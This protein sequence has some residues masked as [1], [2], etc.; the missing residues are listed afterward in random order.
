M[1]IIQEKQRKMSSSSSYIQIRVLAA[2]TGTTYPINLPENE[3]TVENI[4]RHLAAVVPKEDQ[5][6]LL[7]PP[8]KVPKDQTLR[9]TETLSSL[10]LGDMEDTPPS[11]FREDSQSDE[12]SASSRRRWSIL[13]TKDNTGAKRLFLFSKKALSDSAP[14]P[15]PC[16]LHPVDINIPSEPDPSPILF[17]DSPQPSSPLHQALSVYERRFMLHLCQ[18][19]A[20]ADGADL[21]L[22]A[23]RSCIFEQAVMVRALR[24][25]VSNLSDHWNN[26]SRTRAD[27]TSL[28]ME[29]MDEHGKMLNGLDGIL[30]NLGQINLHKELKAIARI[31]GREMETLLDTVPVERERRWANQCQVAYNRL[32]EHFEEVKGEFENLTSTSKRSEE[33]ESDLDT[34]ARVKALEDEVYQVVVKVRNDQ[35]L[36][37]TKLTED[38]KTVVGV[39]LN[40]INDNDR[41][42]AAFTTLE[43]MSKASSDILPLMEADDLKLKEV[44]LKVAEAKTNAMKH[45]QNRLRQI[46]QAQL[47]I[48]RV[49]KIVSGLKAA[50]VQQCEDMT[51]VAH[52]VELPSAYRDFLAEIRRRRAYGEAVTSISNNMIEQITALRDDEVKSREKFLR[53]SGRHLMPSFF[54]MFVPTLATPPPLFT[55][56]LP[57]NIELNELPNISEAES[58]PGDST[59]VHGN[60][61]TSNTDQ[62]A[63]SLTESLPASDAEKDPVLDSISRMSITKGDG[64]SVGKTHNLIISTEEQSDTD[65]IMK[66]A[67]DVVKAECDMKLKTLA[68]ENAALR[69]SLERLGG[70]PSKSFVEDSQEE[71]PRDQ[72]KPTITEETASRIQLDLESTKKELEM[73][74]SE[75]DK[76]NT[77]LAQMKI[78]SNRESDKISHS[79]FK[80][81]DVALFMPTGRA[82]A[83]KRTYLAFHSNCPHRYLSMHNIEGNPDYVL[84]RITNQEQVVAGAVGTDSN[85]HNLLVGTKFWVLTV[86]VLN[87]N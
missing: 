81:G 56:H 29:R 64:S 44:M 27:F 12:T 9:S 16:E 34:E 3:L 50:L 51:H 77:A 48:Q 30:E 73:A 37:L 66:S 41:V 45:M 86:D 14:E 35:A 87:L 82:S 1:L 15:I 7:G 39:I 25:A 13:G 58:K 55:P 5:I 68:Y 67:N 59:P 2:S 62:I 52:L 57:E 38:H 43:D 20:Y 28:Y 71:T 36:R 11:T 46:S 72:L 24:S 18:G 8:Y 53:G 79:S 32:H 70:K 75:L 60:I 49:L 78:D 42:Q 76:A 63:S 69:Q 80:V 21:R 54:E 22:E 83:G 33:A 4:Q 19:R 74:R 31:N 65:V 23:I 6:L 10:R 26:A 85:P 47:K 17:N 84:G 40:A 61:T